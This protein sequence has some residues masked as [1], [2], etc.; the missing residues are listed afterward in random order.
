MDGNVLRGLISSYVSLLFS[1]LIL[2]QQEKRQV[3]GASF[4]LRLATTSSSDVLPPHEV[5]MLL[6]V[7]LDL[8][9]TTTFYVKVLP[10]K[11]SLTYLCIFLFGKNCLLLS[12]RC[13][14]QRLNYGSC[15][16]STHIGW[17]FLSYSTVQSLWNSL[18]TCVDKIQV[19]ISTRLL[20]G[21]SEPAVHTSSQSHSQHVS[22]AS[23]KEL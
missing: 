6:L 20:K 12:S 13:W 8:L 5:S 18:N 19:G 16:P 17:L 7:G 2:D 4:L 3:K 10:C 1:R 22:R 9:R 14:W 15:Q 11:G 23:W 21:K